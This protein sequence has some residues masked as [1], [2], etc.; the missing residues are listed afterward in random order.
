MKN[1]RQTII[2]TLFLINTVISYGQIVGPDLL[3]KSFKTSFGV[4]GGVNLSTIENGQANIAFS[5]EFITGFNAGA[6]MN[7]HF[8]YRNQGSPAGTGWFGIQ[9]EL[10]YS[11]QGFSVDG[12]SIKL[13]YFSLPVLAKLYVTKRFNIQVGPHFSYMLSA[14]PNSVL[15]SD[16]EIETKNLKGS[17]DIGLTFGASF[18]TKLGLLLDVRYNYG[19]TDI[20]SNLIWKNN[21]VAVSFGWMF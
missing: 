11:Q 4:K 18:E 16:L 7:F 17:T 1:K 15:I 2:T 8:G 20:A 21:V 14:S 3:T 5:P 6:F 19:L 13:N 12:Q 9:P 10:L